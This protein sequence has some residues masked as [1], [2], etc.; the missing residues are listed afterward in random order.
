MITRR[1]IFVGAGVGGLTVVLVWGLVTGSSSS[2][3]LSSDDDSA[4]ASRGGL[5]DD[6]TGAFAGVFCGVALAAGF[7]SSSEELTSDED[8]F[9]FVW[10]L[11]E[12]TAEAL[13]D[14]F[15]AQA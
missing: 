13:I 12:V 7:S 14:V 1:H 6:I 3:E 10:T 8:S 11:P 9:Y 2:L 4:A 5:I 15:V